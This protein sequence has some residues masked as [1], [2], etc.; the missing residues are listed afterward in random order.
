MFIDELFRSVGAV[1]SGLFARRHSS[2]DS[3]SMTIDM[4]QTP[5]GGGD[6]TGFLKWRRY[7]QCER[8]HLSLSRSGVLPRVNQVN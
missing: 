4:V 3:S 5:A 2:R 8:S 7:Q 6:I 1:K